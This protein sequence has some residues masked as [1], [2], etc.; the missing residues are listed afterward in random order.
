MSGQYLRFLS[1]LFF[2]VAGI[3]LEMTYTPFSGPTVFVSI[4]TAQEIFRV[5]LMFTPA[6]HSV[7][8]VPQIC[9]AFVDNCYDQYYSTSHHDFV[10]DPPVW[11]GN[12]WISSTVIDDVTKLGDDE[13]VTQRFFLVE[14]MTFTNPWFRDVAGTLSMA[15]TRPAFHEISVTLFQK[16]T[17]PD[18][19]VLRNT[20]VEEDIPTWSTK[21]GSPSLWI[22]EA[23]SL[24]LSGAEEVVLGMPILIDPAMTVIVFPGYLRNLLEQG[25]GLRV[26]E[27]GTLWA[28]CDREITFRINLDDG[29][30][31]N[32]RDSYL[33]FPEN[34]GLMC[35]LWA[36]VSEL[37]ESMV[38]GRQLL[39]SVEKM[40]LDNRDGSIG[41]V[42]PSPTV[43]MRPL[44][45]LRTPVR[46]YRFPSLSYHAEG[47]FSILFEPVPAES[48]K[49]YMLLWTYPRPIPGSFGFRFEFI[50]NQ[51]EGVLNIA[52]SL[53]DLGTCGGSFGPSLDP[54]T[55]SVMFRCDETGTARSHVV[56]SEDSEMGTVFLDFEE[57]GGAAPQP[58]A[59]E[60]A[61]NLPASTVV[62][63]SED[64]KY[65][66]CSICLEEMKAGDTQQGMNCGHRYHYD[67]LMTWLNRPTGP[68][69]CPYCRQRS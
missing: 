12:G 40:I 44:I 57:I 26:S 3:N 69:N 52:D 9:P 22:F 25:W 21:S 24:S 41:F 39:N 20:C 7:L 56:L 48:F 66:N 34:L 59:D 35:K 36:Q 30:A 60:G 29:L 33:R 51:F 14:D 11:F 2:A 46:L 31:I 43:E 65:Q 58:M 61:L 8:Y 13:E 15:R 55:G 32:I 27:D 42:L 53:L 5:A 64:G 18:T 49:G 4:G 54:L 17:E 19:V 1:S 62:G 47:G 28:P 38:I 10:I 63:L 67:C 23:D 16:P 68:K 37:G 45:S 6:C 50:R